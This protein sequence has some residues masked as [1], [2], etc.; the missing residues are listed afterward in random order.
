MDGPGFGVRDPDRSRQVV[1][2]F[3]WRAVV[4]GAERGLIGKERGRGVASW[5]SR[6][7]AIVPI[8]GA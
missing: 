2:L 4:A 8:A 1:E 5:L 3:E 6:R 7:T